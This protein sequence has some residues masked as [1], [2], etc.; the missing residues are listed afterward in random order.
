MSAT[1][2]RAPE[3]CTN[4]SFPSTSSSQFQLEK[5]SSIQCDDLSDLVSVDEFKKRCG[6]LHSA[7]WN[8]VTDNGSGGDHVS[9]VETAEACKWLLYFTKLYSAKS[10]FFLINY[11]TAD[12]LV[13]WNSL[14]THREISQFLTAP[15]RAGPLSEREETEC[16][17]KHP[18][19]V[20]QV[21]SITRF[22]ITF[23]T[24][25]TLFFPQMTVGVRFK[26]ITLNRRD[27]LYTVPVHCHLI[28]LSW[29]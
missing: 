4:S 8:H 23:L 27:S 10:F 13:S 18:I 21:S 20:P 9:E 1:E 22:K 15:R 28:L 14:L 7:V 24:I 2:R 11:S 25:I 19:G 17:R 6:E 16:S 29:R 26:R 12:L 5:Y 3:A